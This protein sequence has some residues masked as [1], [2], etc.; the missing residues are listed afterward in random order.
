MQSQLSL[1]GKQK[2]VIYWSFRGCD[3]STIYHSSFVAHY[4]NA[5]ISKLMLFPFYFEL[6]GV[7]KCYYEEDYGYLWR[8][9]HKYE[10]KLG[11]S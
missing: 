9:F 7:N 6:F 8:I 5:E 10:E 11:G 1:I 4:I 3:G 2:I